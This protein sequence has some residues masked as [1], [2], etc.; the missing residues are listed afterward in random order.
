MLKQTPLTDLVFFDTE[1]T[2]QYPSFD[3][4]PDQRIK[5]LFLKK[6]EKEIAETKVFTN[7]EAD[8]ELKLPAIEQI[9]NKKAPLYAEFGKVIAVTVGKIDKD[10]NFKTLNIADSDEKKLLT[11][12]STR[13]EAFTY[14]KLSD[15]KSSLVAYNGLVFDIPF[16]AK[17][18]CL[19]GMEIPVTLDISGMKSWDIKWVIDPKDH[20]KMNVWDG[21]TSLDL[22]CAAFGVASSK[23]DMDG[24]MIKDVYW[25]DKDLSKISKYCEKDVVAL[26]Q[27][28]LK[29]QNNINTIKI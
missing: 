18:F 3:A 12:L 7:E 27:V 28:Y 19:N 20:W 14:K 5:L 10:F 25:K 26:A 6:F 13:V 2:S 15:M 9:Y 21:N 22:L 16:L 4:I 11:Q 23:D 29:L 17:R 1:S 24:S 8:A